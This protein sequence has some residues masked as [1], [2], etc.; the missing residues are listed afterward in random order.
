MKKKLELIKQGKSKGSFS[1]LFEQSKVEKKEVK[2][3]AVNNAEKS[4]DCI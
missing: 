3:E 2:N 1:K 4:K